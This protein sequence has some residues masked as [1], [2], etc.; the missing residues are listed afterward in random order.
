MDVRQAIDQGRVTSLQILVV[1][2]CFVI[3]MLDGMDVLAIS[4]AAP[5]LSQ[6]WGIT[7]QTLGRVFSAALFGMALGSLFLAPLADVLGRR[8][9][10]MICLTIIAV[11]MVSTAYSTTIPQLVT[12]RFVTGLGVGGVLA[13]MATM[14]AEFSPA[15]SRNLFVTFVQSGY[16]VGAAVLGIIV[17]EGGMLPAYGWSSV[18]LLAGV[19]TA[20]IVPV[21]AL[22]MPESL[23]FLLKRQP[24]G[25]LDDIN[26]ILR[27][28][29]HEEISELPPLEPTSS[30]SG[31]TSMLPRVGALFAPEHR[32]KTLLLWVAF[33]MSFGTLYFLLSWVPQLGRNAGLPLDRA[34]YASVIL[35]LSAFCG[36]V[37]L[38]YLADRFGLKR[39]IMTWLIL[40]A[41]CMSAFEVFASPLTIML[42]IGFIGFTME[43]GFIGIY[44]ASARV[45]P[46]LIRNTGVG[47]AIG[48][49]RAG[50]IVGPIFAGSLVASGITMG[51][52]FRI[53]AIP[54]LL[55]AIAV[56]FMRS[57]ELAPSRPQSGGS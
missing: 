57:K 23:E 43:G 11:G 19:L 24:A 41:I 35:N 39:I 17:V 52:S 4:L 5:V 21:V 34:I 26:Q 38:G 44:A 7:P 2:L 30:G 47:W 8:K 50:A 56:F 10:I 14:S 33:F 45:Y 3:N 51:G 6:D 36:M 15:R 18:F 46:T 28:M 53:F 9:L 20:I 25:A 27:R 29:G 22:K 1:C 31:S 42:A 55:A 12:L 13:S 49:G 37:T 54:L 40:A 16:P 48:A 32:R